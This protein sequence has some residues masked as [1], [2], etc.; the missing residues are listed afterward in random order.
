MLFRNVWYAELK[1]TRGRVTK[2][3]PFWSVAKKGLVMRRLSKLSQM[4]VLLSSAKR[5]RDS[6]RAVCVLNQIATHFET[7]NR[8]AGPL[9]MNVTLMIGRGAWVVSTA[10]FV[11]M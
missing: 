11:S 1:S 8:S 4:G 2:R 9:P 6:K 7:V 3:S 5:G 10:E